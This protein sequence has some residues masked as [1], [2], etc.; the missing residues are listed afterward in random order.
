MVQ[1]QMRGPDDR[2]ELLT[3]AQQAFS[4]AAYTVCVVKSSAVVDFIAKPEVTEEGSRDPDH[5]HENRIFLKVLGN[6]ETF[7]DRHALEM[8]IH[9]QFLDGTPL[10]VAARYSKHTIQNG[11]IYLRHSISCVNVSTLENLLGNGINPCRVAVRGSPSPSVSIDGGRLASLFDQT[12]SKTQKEICNDLSLPRQSLLGYFK[13][14]VKPTVERFNLIVSYLA[15]NTGISKAKVEEEILKPIDVLSAEKRDPETDLNQLEQAF[16]SPK[17]SLEKEVKEHLQR[18]N[19]QSI[20]F[21]SLPW[22]GLISFPS[23]NPNDNVKAT[24]QNEDR[25]FTGIAPLSSDLHRYRQRMGASSEILGNLNQ[26][27]M[28]IV[29][30]EDLTPSDLADDPRHFSV[31]SVNKFFGINRAKDLKHE[32]RESKGKISL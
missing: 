27:L 31:I 2:H 23:E 14:Q 7:K 18:I 24:N 5:L 11:V 10:L 8:K 20:W 19:I 13:E 29:E 6:V 15:Q 3:R 17:N 1:V 25:A 32:I 22:D 21:H 4:D 9:C 16:G 26:N 12:R 28:V 30:D